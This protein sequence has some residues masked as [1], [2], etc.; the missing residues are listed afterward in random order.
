MLVSYSTIDLHDPYEPVYSFPYNEY[1]VNETTNH[2]LN[3]VRYTDSVI[4]KIM[5]QLESRGL[6]ET[7]LVIFKG[8]HGPELNPNGNI[9][10][11]KPNDLYHRVPFLTNLPTF[12][13]QPMGSREIQ[14][15]WTGIDVL[16]TILDSLGANKSLIAKYKGQSLLRKQA[17]NPSERII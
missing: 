8:D 6:L 14:G 3:L 13:T 9:G 4:G 17:L 2:F 1:T 10:P 15:R 7:S 11:F 5:K 12:F 16:P